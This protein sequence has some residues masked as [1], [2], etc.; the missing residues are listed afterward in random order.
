MI[1]RLSLST[2]FLVLAALTLL[3]LLDGC[4]PSVDAAWS[5]VRATGTLCVGMDASFP[6]FES[7]GSDGSPQG[8]DVDLAREISSRLELEPQFVVNLPYDGLY[9]ALTADRVDIVISALVVNPSRT[10]DYAYSRTYFNGGQV[11]VARQGNR[12]S[13]SLRDLEGHTVAVVLGT[14]GDRVGRGWERRASDLSVIQYRTPAE[15]LRAVGDGIT[16]LALV[17]HVSALAEMG[18]GTFLTIVDNAVTEVPYA[19]AVRADSS[20]LLKKVNRALLAMEA[21]GTMDQ[22]IVKWLQ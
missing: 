3:S 5:R 18:E 2:L 15:A 10:A 7:I 11:L 4:S 13:A 9:D 1:R 12:E 19:C 21:D 17:D 6:P 14:A 16:D 20:T 8:L 22:L